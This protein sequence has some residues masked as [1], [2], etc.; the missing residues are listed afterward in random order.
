MHYFKY[1]RRYLGEREIL[2][3]QKDSNLQKFIKNKNTQIYNI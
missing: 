1:Y 2:I 3:S